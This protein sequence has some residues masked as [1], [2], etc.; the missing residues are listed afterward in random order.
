MGLSEPGGNSEDGKLVATITAAILALPRLAPLALASGG[1]RQPGTKG[2]FPSY[3]LI[4]RRSQPYLVVPE[5]QNGLERG[6][7]GFLPLPIDQVIL[8]AQ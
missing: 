8:A 1:L 5:P 7:R 6:W 2:C 3:A 4:Q